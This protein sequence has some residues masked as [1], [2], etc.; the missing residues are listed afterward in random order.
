[1]LDVKPATVNVNGVVYF[2]ELAT[3]NSFD[4]GFEDHGIFAWNVDFDF[5]GSHQGTGWRGFGT[6]GDTARPIKEV[7]Q[8]LGVGRLALAKGSRVYT[9][10][11][12]RYGAIQGLLNIDQTKYLL[13][14]EMYKGMGVA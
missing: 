5:G 11:Q 1:M 14:W 10:R 9:L 12:E 3:V 2:M 4:V 7:L 6:E 13:F 8:V